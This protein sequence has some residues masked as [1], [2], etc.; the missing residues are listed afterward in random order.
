MHI[1]ILLNPA[2][3]AGSAERVWHSLEGEFRRPG[4]SCTLHRSTPERGIREICR[5]L[6]GGAVRPGNLLSGECAEPEGPAST[7]SPEPVNLVVIGGDGSCNEALNGIADFANTRFGFLPC[8]TGN[9]LAR[10]LGLPKDLRMIAERILEG[11][12]RRISDVGEVYFPD[13]GECR[14]FQI[15]AGMG[16]DAEICQRVQ[17]SPLKSLLNRLGLGKLIYPLEGVRVILSSRGAS[18]RV[19]TEQGE[20]LMED[21]LAVTGMNRRYQGGGYPFCPKASDH[22][23]QLDL[24]TIRGLSPLQ[25]LMFIPVLKA[26][27]HTQKRGVQT[28]RFREM[29]L[30]S[31]RPLYIHTDGEVPGKSSH[32]ILRLR[33]E[34]L[35]MLV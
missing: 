11:K 25:L 32:V 16:F 27:R 18:I 19:R 33:E 28:G 8:G 7:T 22:D 15:S 26:G 4:I 23:G 2:G 30:F 35:Q 31:D 14:R 34:K 12:V 21:C 6:T 17:C 3:G 24:C 1:D 20:E 5:E 29:E 9:D 13:T 10:D